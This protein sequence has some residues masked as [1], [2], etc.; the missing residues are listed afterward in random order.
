MKHILEWQ[1][2]HCY[3]FFF[4][5]ECVYLLQY[6]LPASGFGRV[7]LELVTR[8]WFIVHTL[9]SRWMVIY[10]DYS[11]VYSVYNICS[12]PVCILIYVCS[13]HNSNVSAKKQRAIWPPVLG[14]NLAS[15]CP[16]RLPSSLVVHL[17]GVFKLLLFV[18][19]VA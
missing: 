13:M 12:Y 8:H 3:R 18:Q 14:D 9:Y 6:R 1:L 2:F 19:F 10:N 5:P 11:T 7:F 15:E 17:Q 4:S 16:I